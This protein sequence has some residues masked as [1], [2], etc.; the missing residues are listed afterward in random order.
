MEYKEMVY[1]VAAC[2]FL[3]ATLWNTKSSKNK[4]A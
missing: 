2:F 3:A 1:F 4:S